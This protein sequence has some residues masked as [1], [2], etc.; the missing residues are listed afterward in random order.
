[1]STLIIGH[2]MPWPWPM[3]RCGMPEPH[4]SGAS[5]TLHHHWA[6]AALHALCH[7]NTGRCDLTTTVIAAAKIDLLFF[8]IC[9]SYVLWLSTPAV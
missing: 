5:L 6:H 1:M 4:H 7:H 9:Y 3:P 8:M 2:I